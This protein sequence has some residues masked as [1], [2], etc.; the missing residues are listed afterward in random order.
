M[1]SAAK[2][3]YF[4]IYGN[5]SPEGAGVAEIVLLFERQAVFC[6]S[7]GQKYTPTY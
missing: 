3:E 6:P 5:F 2:E 7:M 4:K 1:S